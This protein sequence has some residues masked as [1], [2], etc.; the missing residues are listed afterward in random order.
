[1]YDVKN[2]EELYAFIFYHLKKLIPDNRMTY[3][4]I[5]DAL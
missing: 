2:E 5:Y 4:S 1:M 3:L